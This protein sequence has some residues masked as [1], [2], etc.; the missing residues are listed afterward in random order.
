LQVRG[1]VAEYER[2]LIAERMRRGRL[3]K[4]RAGVLLPWTRAPFG[5]GVDPERPRDPAG[6]RINEA[7]AALIRQVFAQYLEPGGTLHGLAR[8]LGQEGA[9]TPSGKRRWSQA[10]LRAM[11]TNPTYTGQLFAGR[12][13]RRPAK[14]RPSPLQPVGSFGSDSRV[15][16]ADWIAVGRIPA[17][18]SEQQFELVRAK[19][20]RNRATARRNNS[21]HDADS[22]ANGPFGSSCS[23]VAFIIL[24]IRP[25]FAGS[26]VRN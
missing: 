8:R 13:R 10:T 24:P 14:R 16:P 19:L 25:T 23:S 3:A 22:Y 5:Y 26:V 20:A 6:V 15:P 2:T 9:R 4:Y 21:T 12:Y 1:A 17:I 11:L 7:Q 18:I